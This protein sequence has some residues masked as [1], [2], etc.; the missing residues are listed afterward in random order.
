MFTRHYMHTVGK[1]FAI[2]SLKRD[3]QVVDIPGRKM[4]EGML[5][6]FCLLN[7]DELSI[8]GCI[9]VSDNGMSMD[10]RYGQ[11]TGMCH[12][13]MTEHTNIDCMIHHNLRDF[14]TTFWWNLYDC[15]H[16][17]QQLGPRH[18]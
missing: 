18:Y 4:E 17:V 16:P 11:F 1:D 10:L 9:N 2:F 8:T 14:T 12:T 5:F 3:R 7:G 6:E 13:L 15:K